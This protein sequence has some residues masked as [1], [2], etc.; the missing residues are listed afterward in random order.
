MRFVD[1][2]HRVSSEVLVTPSG[3]RPAPCMR[4][5]TV[6]LASARCSR[7]VCRPA[8]LGIP[9]T[10]ND[11]LTVH[12]TPRSGGSDS[13]AALSATRRSASSASSLASSKR[14][15]ITALILGFERST[16]SMWVS[17][18]SRA[19]NSPARIALASASAE[20]SVIAAGSTAVSVIAAPAYPRRT[21]GHRIWSWESHQREGDR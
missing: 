16:A 7:R 11:S 9:A 8:E 2:I 3:I 14:V 21:T 15:A 18:T 17:T 5:T 1:S 12:G 20:R 13:P 4:S 19:L 6:A 10:A